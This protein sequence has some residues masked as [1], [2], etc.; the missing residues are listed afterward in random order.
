MTCAVEKLFSF[1]RDLESR[2]WPKGGADTGPQLWLLPAGL[3]FF[4]VDAAAFRTLFVFPGT[5]QAPWH[6]LETVFMFF[7][8]TE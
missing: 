3:L 4:L 6:L 1:Y 8:L 7:F 5:W 2:M